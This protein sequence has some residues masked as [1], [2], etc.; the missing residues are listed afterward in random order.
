MGQRP[1]PEISLDIET[2]VEK[3]PEECGSEL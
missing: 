1:F 2:I 3:N